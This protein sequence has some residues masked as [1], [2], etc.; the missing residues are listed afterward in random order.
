MSFDRRQLPNLITLS[1]LLFAG[2]VF[3]L[4]EALLRREQPQV[5]Q[6]A[7][8]WAFWFFLAASLTD[9]LDGWLARRYGWVTAVGRV[10]DPVV[11]K[12]LTLGAFIYLVQVDWLTDLSDPA[13]YR[14]DWNW[15][16][17]DADYLGDLVPA[18]AVVVLLAREFLITALRGL[19]ESC[20]LQFPADKFG[21]A[22]MTL[23][24]IYICA[25]IGA[26]GAVPDRIHLPF[27]YL[28]REPAL[29]AI[30]FWLVIGLTLFSGLN[31][32]LRAAHLLRGRS[33]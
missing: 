12:V 7:A 28:A 4:L 32:C 1:R 19:V 21:K 6:D 16:T 8:F 33:A 29:M 25:L 10:A 18:W 13:R 14:Q 2:V 9:S 11:D 23:Q 24:T 15:H 27:L 5:Q 22:K 20:G 26:A 30:L 17:G 3:F 31:Y